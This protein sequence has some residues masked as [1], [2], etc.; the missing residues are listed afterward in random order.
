MNHQSGVS[1]RKIAEKFN[2]HRRIVQHELKDMGVYY[3]KKQHAPRNT[4]QQI[5]QVSKC[6]RRLYGA[7][8]EDDY[9]LIMDD[10]KYFT[11]TN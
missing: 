1:L 5:E 11:L 9:Q 7:L 6:S 8:L 4:E 10:K 3:G 2:V